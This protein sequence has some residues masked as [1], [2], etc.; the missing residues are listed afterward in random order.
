M[1]IC[2]TAR[3]VKWAWHLT[4]PRSA[5]TIHIYY[6]KQQQTWNSVNSDSIHRKPEPFKSMKTSSVQLLDQFTDNQFK[7]KL[8]PR[9]YSPGVYTEWEMCSPPQTPHG[10]SFHNAPQPVFSTDHTVFQLYDS[11]TYPIHPEWI[12]L[13]QQACKNLS[14]SHPASLQILRPSPFHPSLPN[15]SSTQS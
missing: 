9:H 10:G 14:H 3:S 7:Q 1:Y 11:T 15:S 13:S 4:E 6:C 5:V 12:T 2:F 8:K